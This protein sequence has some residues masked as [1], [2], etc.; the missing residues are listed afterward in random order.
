MIQLSTGLWVGTHDDERS[1]NVEAVKI[2]AVLNVAQDMAGNRHWP[3]MEYTQVGLVD[4][5]GN[6]VC[7]YISALLCTV[8]LIERHGR[9]LIYDHDG[10]RAIVVGMC[11]L[12]LTQGQHRNSPTSW[13]Y[14]PT[15]DQRWD[16]ILKRKDV[17]VGG[18]PDKAHIEA[19]DRIPWGLLTAL[20]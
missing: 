14:W 20:I 5:P 2:K 12:N 13:G 8:N 10:T 19:F 4:G 15:F 18:K 9:I 1:P 17:V 3:D 16:I 11:Y 7:A 6:L